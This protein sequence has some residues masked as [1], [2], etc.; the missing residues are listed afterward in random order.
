MNQPD[1]DD[2]TMP[3][4]RDGVARGQSF[5]GIPYIDGNGQIIGELPQ[6]YVVGQ[7]F[8]IRNTLGE[9]GMSFVYLC[10]DIALNRQVALK[11]MRV[12]AQSNE[13][14]LMRFRREGQAVAMLSHSNV[15][16]VHSLQFTEN[17]Q[18]FLVMEV[19]QGVSLSQLLEISGPLRLPRA[20]KFL[21][22]ICDGIAHAHENGVIHRDLKLSNIMLINPD[23]SDERIKIL[24]FGIA[25]VVNETSVKM[26]QT[27]EV[28]G[29][30]AYMSPE[31]ALGKTVDTKTDQYSLG[32]IAFELLTGRTP[33]AAEN[34]LAVLMAHVQ[35]KAPSVNEFMQVPV[36][37]NIERTIARLLAKEPKDRFE[38]IDEV[39]KA[40]KG[41][42]KVSKPLSINLKKHVNFR[43]V[44]YAGACLLSAGLIAA[45]A[46]ATQAPK[47]GA[48]VSPKASK[49][50]KDVHTLQPSDNTIDAALDTTDDGK[51]AALFV[52]SK[53]RSTF[54]SQLNGTDI[55]DQGLTYLAQCPNL[56]DLSI[57][58]CRVITPAGIA[59]LAKLPLV[60]LALD[61]TNTDDTALVSI[62]TMKQLQKLSVDNCDTIT[63]KGISHLTALS[64]LNELSISDLRLLRG[65]VLKTVAKMKSLTKLHMDNDFIGAGLPYL[66]H[67]RITWLSMGGCKTTTQELLAL[68][69]LRSLVTLRIDKDNVD[70]KTLLA[71][72]K[73]PHLKE[74]TIKKTAIS[75]SAIDEFHSINSQCNL[76]Y[77][78]EYVEAADTAN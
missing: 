78:K 72:A 2:F 1:K 36:P 48:K 19:V 4:R 76:I 31:Q 14:A 51:L 69:K 12:S 49:I 22:Q 55:S 45:I 20:L 47:T 8:K 28:F 34:Y 29:S 30:P 26:T 25:K 33:F 74:L 44:A 21:A 73:L 5:S 52:K 35:E 53:N 7:Q 15:V 71:L 32:C 63:E 27:G 64:N 23:R 40:F 59:K 37:A 70:R 16:K 62:G 17:D 75:R 3:S 9:G 58:N 61:N 18:P 66:A 10:D 77:D 43:Y 60:I 54:G 11:V 24:D 46:F 13:Q 67:S 42:M 6:G 68:T 56:V 39:K 65:D 38:S 50:E 41:E 57:K